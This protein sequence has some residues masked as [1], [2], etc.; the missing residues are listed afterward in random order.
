LL[1]AF[2][3]RGAAAPQTGF[4]LSAFRGNDFIAGFISRARGFRQDRNQ[5][6][7]ELLYEN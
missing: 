3:G 7:R 1:P 2:G 6:Y 5:I 4:A